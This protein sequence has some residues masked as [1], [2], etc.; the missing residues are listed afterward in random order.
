[1]TAAA[2]FQPTDLQLA[3][4]LVFFVVIISAMYTDVSTRR[5]PNE[6]TYPGILAGVVLNMMYASRWA[7]GLQHAAAGFLVG[8]GLFLVLHAMGVI[9]GGGD[10]KLMG[11]V[12]AL[13]GWQFTSNAILMTVLVGGALGIVLLVFNGLISLQR[14]E[15]AARQAEQPPPLQP[16]DDGIPVHRVAGSPAPTGDASDSDKD[17]AEGA[18]RPGAA[19][20]TPDQPTASSA[21]Q[22]AAGSAGEPAGDAVAAPQTAGDGRTYIPYGLSIA[23]GSFWA[24]SLKSSSIAPVSLLVASGG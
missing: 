11:A 19:E 14:E 23:L 16:R 18:A 17:P 2:I 7:D 1:M 3:I 5:V 8:F 10:V 15:D 13:T 22:P 20:A 24:Y 4:H 9:E 6:I 12:G 21:E